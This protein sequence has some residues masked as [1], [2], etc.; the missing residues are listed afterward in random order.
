MGIDP[1]SGPH[2]APGL[3]LYFLHSSSVS[4]RPI[5]AA[6]TDAV[7]LTLLVDATDLTD[8]AGDVTAG[9]TFGFVP[10]AE[11]TD[12]ASASSARR[13]QGLG[14]GARGWGKETRLSD[15]SF[16]WIQGF[17]SRAKGKER[18]ENQSSLEKRVQVILD[19]CCVC[20]IIDLQDR[21]NF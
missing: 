20:A 11:G 21:V 2:L 14:F 13:I 8:L 1:G 3:Q 17:G 18:E 7:V 4:L 10:W 6:A 5:L 9:L 16:R 15:S 12:A 19:L